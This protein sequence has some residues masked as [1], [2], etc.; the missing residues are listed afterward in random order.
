MKKMIWVLVALLPMLMGLS[1]KKEEVKKGTVELNF[2]GAFG[3]DP[4]VMYEQ[5][6]PYF[7][8]NA[9]KFQLFQFYLSDIALI[10]EDNGQSVPLSEVALVSFKDVQTPAAAQAGI[11]IKGDEIP[12]G[13]Y[14][15]IK[16]GLGVSPKLNATNPGHYTPPHP[17]DDN[18]WSWAAGYVFM[19]IEG[20]ADNDGD[21]Q[22]TDKLTFHTGANDL[23]REHTWL[24]TIDVAEG[25]SITIQFNV[26]LERVLS[27][28]A[29]HFLD[30]RTYTQDHT[31][32][33]DVYNFLWDNLEPAIQLSN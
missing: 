2:K 32:N 28:D 26:D 29:S 7:D 4:L 16:A 6:Y 31:N 17:L 21:G 19:K 25:Q 27:T 10:R 33:P 13:R 14:K 3:S 20:N 5:S 15:G 8:N 11:T 23:Y 22:F 9:V 30:F 12:I 24:K 1:C 18:Y